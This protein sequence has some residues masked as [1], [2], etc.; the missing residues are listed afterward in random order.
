MFWLGA[1]LSCSGPSTAPLI[2][3]AH[4]ATSQAIEIRVTGSADYNQMSAR[5]SEVQRGPDRDAGVVVVLE[6]GTYQHTLHIGSADLPMDLTIRGTDGVWFDGAGIDAEGRDI[7]VENVGFRGR[8]SSGSLVSITASGR[9]LVSDLRVENAQLG[10]PQ[11]ASTAQPANPTEARERKRARGKRPRPS[12][13]LN[14][15]T[16]ETGEVLLKG[17]AVS[18]SRVIS[19]ALINVSGIPAREVVLEGLVAPGLSGVE[20]IRVSSGTTVTRR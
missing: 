16:T 18:D 19:P 1:L 7:T 11:P 9:V 14:I 17:I 5:V 13:I 4:P 6:A 15:N 2:D 3:D 20:D 8:T 12:H 10:Q